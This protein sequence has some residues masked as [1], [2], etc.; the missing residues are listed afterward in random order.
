MGKVKPCQVPP[1]FTSSLP[2]FFIFT[3]GA[4]HK[5]LVL[6]NEDDMLVD[7]FDNYPKHGPAI[8]TPLGGAQIK[9]D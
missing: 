1:S 3:F 2:L 5:A 7:S 8:L 6:S 4:F 9:S